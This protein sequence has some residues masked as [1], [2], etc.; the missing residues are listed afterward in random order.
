LSH[1][2]RSASGKSSLPFIDMRD[3][4]FSR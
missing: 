3:M 4:A 1:N 2:G